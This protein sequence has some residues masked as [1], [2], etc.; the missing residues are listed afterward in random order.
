MWRRPVGLDS[1]C[2]G[3]D[4]AVLGMVAQWRGWPHR[5]RGDREDLLRRP[6]VRASSLAGTE[7]VVIPLSRV[8]SSSFEGCDMEE[9][10]EWAAQ[11]HGMTLAFPH[12]TCTMPGM[13]AQCGLVEQHQDLIPRWCQR[14]GVAGIHL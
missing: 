12:S 5:T 8:P 1:H 14:T 11:C 2:A 9:V 10:R 4:P 13:A 7:L 3:A 6:Y